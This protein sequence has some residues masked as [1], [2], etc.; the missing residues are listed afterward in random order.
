[1]V[2]AAVAV[3]AALVAQSVP[4]TQLRRQRRPLCAAVVRRSRRRR[5]ELARATSS[6]RAHRPRGGDARRRAHVLSR[7]LAP[8]SIRSGRQVREGD[9]PGHLRD[10]LRAAGARRSAGQRLGRRRR[11]EHARRSS[12]PRDGSCWCSAESPRAITVRPGPGV[13]ARPDATSSAGAPAPA[14]GGGG[15]GGGGGGAAA[16]A[17]GR[18]HQRRRLQPAVRCD[19]G[20]APA[21]S[22][23]P[24]DSAPTTASRSSTRTATS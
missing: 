8:V 13:P 20:Q 19:V 24:T 11:L 1:M 12:M 21:T 4:E 23:S 14:A 17:A 15:G 9:R 3:G 16:A 18:R 5:D 7:R 2:A 6:L 10:Q 22:T